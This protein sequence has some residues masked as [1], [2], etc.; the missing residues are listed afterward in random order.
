MKRGHNRRSQ[1]DTAFEILAA[2]SIGR[3]QT[4]EIDK[5]FNRFNVAAI[6]WDAVRCRTRF[7][8]LVLAH[9]IFKPS[10]AAASV[11]LDSLALASSADG[12]WS[13]KWRYINDLTNT[14]VIYFHVIFYRVGQIK[15]GQLTFLLV[16]SECIYKIILF[17]AG[18]NYTEQQVTWCQF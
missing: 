3:L 15:R 16:T 7:C 12:M 5:I 14:S 6:D 18:I 4:S 17:L 1:S 9:E 10:G 13:F 8:S 2:A 11:K